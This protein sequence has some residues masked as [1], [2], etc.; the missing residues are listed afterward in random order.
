MVPSHRFGLLSDS[1]LVSVIIPTYNRALPLNRCLESL[2]A[3]TYGNFEVIIVD[4]GST[5]NTFD[6]VDLFSLRLSTLYIKISNSGGPA[7]PRN[8]AISRSSGKYIAFLDSD[9]SWAPTK[10]EVCL[11]FLQN[12]A[13]L[14]YHD[15]YIKV[16]SFFPLRAHSIPSRQVSVPVYEHLLRYGN[17]IVNSSVVVSRSLLEK[18]L[19]ID[20]SSDL[21]AAEDFDLWLRLAQYS[22]SFLY[23]PRP[24]LCYQVSG[25]N[26]S[27]FTRKYRYTKYIC[28]KHG[29]TSVPPAGL[30]DWALANLAT[31]SFRLRLYSESCLYSWSLALRSSGQPRIIKFLAMIAASKFLARFSF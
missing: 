6:V 1:P 18:A 13:D 2:C 22:D 15:A 25:D 9:D 12:G 28:A 5:D 19:P 29:L 14:V 11:K 21:I 4:D 30:P 17:S 23:I 10:L 31:S 3:Q 7:R 26:I 16:R 24:L 27:S 8:L 20:E